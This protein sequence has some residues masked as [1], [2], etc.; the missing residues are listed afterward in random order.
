L[1]LAGNFGSQC[2]PGLALKIFLQHANSQR[3]RSSPL[4]K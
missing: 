2:D 1:Q 3:H 4:S